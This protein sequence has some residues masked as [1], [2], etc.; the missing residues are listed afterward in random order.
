VV[1]EG[2]NAVVER[3]KHVGGAIKSIAAGAYNMAGN[4]LSTVGG[5][6]KGAGVGFY[7]M[8]RSG[9]G[10]AGGAIKAQQPAFIMR[11]EKA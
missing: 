2:A 5:A 4:C 9:L 7:N 1:A 10:T 11:P 6:I 3:T 8:A